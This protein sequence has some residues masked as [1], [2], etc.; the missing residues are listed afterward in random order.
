MALGAAGVLLGA[1][2]L[3][4][5]IQRM[6]ALLRDSEI[7]SLPAT[8]GGDITLDA[9]G[10]CVLHVEQPRLNLA[11]LHARFALRDLEAGNDVPSSPVLFRTTVSGFATVRWAARYFE[12]A[13][14]GRYRLMVD[15]I[16][17]DSDLS[18]IRLIFTRPFAAMLMLSILGIL[19]GSICLIGSIVFTALTVTGKI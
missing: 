16:N 12:I 4:F 17:P 7:A 13:H 2:V 10:T 6:F 1:I 3:Y 14:A 9:V 5:C 18:R 15:G 19:C 11:M 8:T